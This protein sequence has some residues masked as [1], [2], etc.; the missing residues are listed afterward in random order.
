MRELKRKKELEANKEPDLEAMQEVHTK[1][2]KGIVMKHFTRGLR[3]Q[4]I[5]RNGYLELTNFAE[6][7]IENDKMA[8]RAERNRCY[9]VFYKI[10]KSS[11]FTFIIAFC[12]ALNTIILA[13]D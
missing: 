11:T 9:M 13:M 1:M 12:I 6:Q 4:F 2:Q 7:V 10:V 8:L 3:K 5:N